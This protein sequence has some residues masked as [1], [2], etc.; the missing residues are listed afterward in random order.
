MT[1]FV[2]LGVGLGALIVGLAFVGESRAAVYTIPNPSVAYNTTVGA[3]ATIPTIRQQDKDW[4]FVYTDAPGTN[5]QFTLDVLGGEDNHVLT[6]ADAGSGQ[7]LLPGV[8]NL[9]Y[10][11]AVN[12]PGATFV[13]V[14]L[15]ATFEGTGASASITKWLYTSTDHTTFIDQLSVNDGDANDYTTLVAGLTFLDVVEQI[16][17]TSG[18]V[19]GTTNTFVEAVPEPATIVMWSMLGGVGL[20]FAYRR[21][22][23]AT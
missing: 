19:K 6:L 5:A 21:R 1:K 4:T 11:I 20:I 23:R 13:S 22:K 17:V 16:V 12:S 3:W 7:I 14:S 8:Y 15:G 18:A 9:E 10:T 2:K